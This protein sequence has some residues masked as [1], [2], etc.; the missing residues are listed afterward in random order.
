M[1]NTLDLKK[2]SN[3]VKDS[4]DSSE[5]KITKKVSEDN[6]PE[7]KPA[8]IDPLAL[9]Q[10]SWRGPTS[11]NKA[12]E[13]WV[14]STMAVMYVLAILSWVIYESII[15]T[16]MFALLGILIWAHSR[17]EHPEANFNVHPAGISVDN[18]LHSFE[19]I[20]SFWID[21]KP[22]APKELSVQFNKWHTN[23][24]KIPIENQNP[25]R[26]RTL[27]LQYVPEEKHED[28]IVELV[29]QKLGL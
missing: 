17:K 21:Y 25:L 4:E 26:L 24:L 16:V 13:K 5:I 23:Y 20:K 29:Q 18:N 9:Q 12:D 27:L 10:I 19:D 1:E 8:K 14:Y 3:T 22:E 2:Q 7:E 15:T 28:T 11:L 6:D